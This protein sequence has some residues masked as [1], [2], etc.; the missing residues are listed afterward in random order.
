MTGVPQ[1]MEFDGP[2][3]NDPELS[4]EQ[5]ELLGELNVMRGDIVTLG[6]DTIGD[7]LRDL[8]QKFAEV[9]EMLLAQQ[10]AVMSV[11]KQASEHHKKMHQLEGRLERLE[12]GKAPAGQ[13]ADQ[14]YVLPEEFNPP[15]DTEESQDV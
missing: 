2:D 1:Y 5:R 11:V 10:E 4:D 3:Y 14:I 8:I 7:V 6:E 12:S 9:S 15:A 13:L